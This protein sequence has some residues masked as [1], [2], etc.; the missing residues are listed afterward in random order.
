MIQLWHYLLRNSLF[1]NNKQNIFFIVKKAPKMGG[2][3]KEESFS[4]YTV[5][6]ATTTKNVLGCS[7]SSAGHFGLSPIRTSGNVSCRSSSTRTFS[8]RLSSW[9]CPIPDNFFCI[10]VFY[11]Q[12]TVNKC[13]NK[14]Y[15][16]KRLFCLLCHN[17]CPID[18]KILLRKWGSNLGLLRWKLPLVQSL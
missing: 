18:R 14:I 3:R 11:L 12:L 4:N 7:L 1:I 16:D 2:S 17:H 9:P 8:L 10:F 15:D 5:L 13:G 6:Y